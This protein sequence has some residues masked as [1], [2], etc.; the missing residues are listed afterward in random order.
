[1]RRNRNITYIVVTLIFIMAFLAS[2]YTHNDREVQ[3]FGT[4]DVTT[5]EPLSETKV[6]PASEAGVSIIFVGDVMTSRT[7][8][9]KMKKN[10]YDYPFSGVIEYLKSADMVFANLETPITP[11]PSVSSGDVVFRSDP[12]VANA[13]ARANIKIVSLANNH[14]MNFGVQGIADTFRYL[15]SAGVDFVGA[16]NNEAE[17]YAPKYVDIDGINFA[18]LAFTDTDVL[19]PGAAIEVIQ[20]GVA[21][22]G[23]AKAKKAIQ[24]AK[25]VAD[26]IVVSM[27]SGTEY[28]AT[29][30][31]RQTNFARG[32]VDAGADLVIGHHPH[33]TQPVERYKGK[34]IFYS[35]GNFVFDQMWSRKTREGE[36]VKIYFSKDGVEKYDLTKIVIDDYSRPKIVQP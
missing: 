13:L 36:A 3:D 6:S 23:L 11:G 31:Q 12:E 28:T 7:V 24:I 35:L 15:M 29:P 19:P 14:S 5:E 33:W 2:W 32:V 27:H 26:V 16:G 8:A 25:G 10:G 34:Y 21:I 18:F 9:Q 20:P 17:T 22:M 1:M 30:N 4:A